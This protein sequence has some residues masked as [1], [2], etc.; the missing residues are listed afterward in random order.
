MVEAHEKKLR[1]APNPL[2]LCHFLAKQVPY[3]YHLGVRSDRQ[4]AASTVE[5]K[6]A[7]QAASLELPAL[8][9]MLAILDPCCYNSESTLGVGSSSRAMNGK[10]KPR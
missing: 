4:A 10:P 8:R 9:R 3:G 1:T 7:W 2:Q 5:D 6:T